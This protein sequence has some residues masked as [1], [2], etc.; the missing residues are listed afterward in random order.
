M[1]FNWTCVTCANN[2]GIKLKDCGEVGQAWNNNIRKVH[3]NKCLACSSGTTCT[4]YND[5]N[6]L[7]AEGGCSD[8]KPKLKDPE[9]STIFD[10][11]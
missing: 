6:K 10:F 1:E 5:N 2:T 3:I 11:I 8:Y 9:Q 7:Q 4:F